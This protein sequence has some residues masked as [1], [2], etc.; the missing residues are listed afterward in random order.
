MP[1]TERKRFHKNEQIYGHGFKATHAYL[2]V[3]GEVELILPGSE[4]TASQKVGK[5]ELFGDVEVVAGAV[6][7]RTAKAITDA[8]E[9]VAINKQV[10]DDAVEESPRL[11]QA[12]IRNL[13]LKWKQGLLAE[14]SQ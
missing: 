12:T 8:V 3:E 2:V 14:L 5:G 4:T 6:Y 11:L 7:S 10:F 1:D 9:V 13:C